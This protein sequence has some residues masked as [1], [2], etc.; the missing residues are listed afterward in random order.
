MKQPPASPDS[1]T[2]HGAPGTVRRRITRWRQGRVEQTDD[3]VAEE[4][5]IAMTYNGRSFAVM[6]ATPQDL[7]DFAL[8]FSLSEGLVRTPADLLAVDV[9][10]LL[11]GT[12]LAM[13]VAADAHGAHLDADGQR[14]LPGRSGCGICG[15]RQLETAVRQ[16][17][18]VHGDVGLTHAGLERALANLQQRQPMNAATGAVHAAAWAT[19][20]GEI[21]LVREDVGR[22]NALDK[23]I[24][25]LARLGIRP[26]DGFIVMTSRASYELARKCVQLQVPLLATISAPSS[27][28][29][30]HAQAGQLA[31]LAFCRG[32]SVTRFA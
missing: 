14:L 11:E 4:Q 24:G 17:G 3:W 12:E 26:A 23:L 32:D 28:A 18:A 20:D 7:E 19:A 30:R 29:I 2:G 25:R 1:P 13:T 27:L 10:P 5:P 6:M 21:A 16:P 8:G 9:R 31:L 15:T 22:H